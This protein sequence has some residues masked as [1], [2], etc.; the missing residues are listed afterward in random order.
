MKKTVIIHVVSNSK[1]ESAA[2]RP[3]TEEPVSTAAPVK[4]D[5]TQCFGCAPLN[6]KEYFARLNAFVD[7]NNYFAKIM[8]NIM[9]MD[10]EEFSPWKAIGLMSSLTR[11]SMNLQILA[12]E[13]YSAE[14]PQAEEMAAHASDMMNNVNHMINDLWERFDAATGLVEYGEDEEDGFDAEKVHDEDEDEEEDDDEE[15]LD[16]SSSE[17]LLNEIQSSIQKLKELFKENE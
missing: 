9:R 10:D 2:V 6:I 11:L 1:P 17:D 7:R 8:H 12:N 5:M 15:K 13:L 16:Q 14:F 4:E 3:Q